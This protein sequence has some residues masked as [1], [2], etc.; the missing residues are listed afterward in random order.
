MDR[1]IRNEA[2]TIVG[3]GTQTKDFVH[4]EDVLRGMQLCLGRKDVA[5]G[6]FNIAT[7][8]ATGIKE[9]AELI[10]ALTES[11]SEIVYIP[12]Q[13]ESVSNVADITRAKTVLGYEPKIGLREGLKHYIAW[14]KTII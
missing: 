4:V 3:D 1:A 9:L 13:K 12:S 6:A 10:T 8:I 11:S 14:Y 2:L 7:G 5:G